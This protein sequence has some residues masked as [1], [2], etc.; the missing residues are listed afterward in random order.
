MEQKATVIVIQKVE[1][2]YNS[3]EAKRL[4]IE[5]VQKDT[6]WIA[7]SE[8]A[9]LQNVNQFGAAKRKVLSVTLEK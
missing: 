2:S 6:N 3:E 5:R 4:C 1:I 9:I 7:F 8:G